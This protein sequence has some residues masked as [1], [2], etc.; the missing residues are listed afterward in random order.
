MMKRSSLING[1]L[2]TTAV[3][4]TGGASGAL[5]YKN[6]IDLRDK[7]SDLRYLSASWLPASPAD[8]PDHAQTGL[9]GLENLVADNS[10]E[11]VQEDA[12]YWPDLQI[13]SLEWPEL[14]QINV[15]EFSLPDVKL[16]EMKFP[17]IKIP[18]IKLPEFELPQVKMPDVKMP[19]FK[20]PEIKTPS[21][22]TGLQDYLVGR[23]SD[24][25][26]SIRNFNFK[27][28]SVFLS[29]DQNA[30]GNL[31]ELAGISPAAGES[32][33]GVVTLAQ[34]EN[35]YLF[36]DNKAAQKSGDYKYSIEEKNIE[37]EGVLVPQKSTVISSSK[38]GKIAKIHFD[39]GDIFREGD[40]L[41]EYECQDLRAEMEI[42]EAEKDYTAQKVMRNEKLLKLDIISDIEHLGVKAEEV[43][44]EGQARVIASKMDQCYIRAAYDG[45]VTK[46]L[47]NDHE[48]TR[49][50]RILM[51]V[52]S[53]DHLQVEFLLPSRWLRW[54]NIDA[55]VTLA[56]SETGET[57][58]AKISRIHG[59]IDPVSQSIQMSANLDTHDD[60][61]LPGMSGN[62]TI[63]VP[64]IRAE[65]IHG[66]LEKPR[67]S[68]NDHMPDAPPNM[69]E[70]E[71]Q[72]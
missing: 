53:M 51:E 38:D 36:Q 2:L 17:E 29:D 67:Y 32:D 4:I 69:P 56:V 44:A 16:P 10:L 59:E 66:F 49:S 47:A 1:L 72:Q 65:G 57:Y 34:R 30:P 12:N 3:L 18:E 21:F 8:A 43:K 31:A 52:A 11:A 13:T 46:R 15:P 68:N 25:H 22:I 70:D 35:G 24:I 60:P 54:V 71:T 62:I 40:V 27:P 55:P 63:D 20:M 45:R 5:L 48:F 64:A 39:D 9:D 14:P 26:D 19:E 50:D 37:V 7:I 58:Q 23:V 33:T 41:V 28:T 42:A 61:L 6:D